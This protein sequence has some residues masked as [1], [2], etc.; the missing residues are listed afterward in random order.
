MTKNGRIIEKVPEHLPEHALRL[1][2]AVKDLPNVEIF[3]NRLE[4][5]L[6]KFLPG[7]DL[8]VNFSPDLLQKIPNEVVRKINEE[9]T[10]N[11]R[12]TLYPLGIAAGLYGL[13]E[14]KNPQ[15]FKEE[16]AKIMFTPKVRKWF[17]YT[18]FAQ[19]TLVGYQ[20]EYRINKIGF[21]GAG[22]IMNAIYSYIKGK[23][24]AENLFDHKDP[25]FRKKEGTLLDFFIAQALETVFLELEEAEKVRTRK[26]EVKKI[27]V[28]ELIRKLNTVKYGEFVTYYEAAGAR[29]TLTLEVLDELKKEIPEDKI[30]KHFRACVMDLD[31][32]SIKHLQENIQN[33]DLL[34]STMMAITGNV[35]R[36]QNKKH[37]DK[38][39]TNTNFNTTVFF[40]D[41]KFKVDVYVKTGLDDYVGLVAQTDSDQQSQE[42]QTLAK[43]GEILRNHTKALLREPLRTYLEVLVRD[44]LTV[45]KKKKDTDNKDSASFENSIIGKILGLSENQMIKSMIPE[46]AYVSHTHNIKNYLKKDGVL[47]TAIFA[48]ERLVHEASTA[49]DMK[50]EQIQDAEKTQQLEELFSY[51]IKL[52]GANW[53]TLSR[54]KE[55]FI[56]KH[57]KFFSNVEVQSHRQNDANFPGLHILIAR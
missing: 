55:W 20:G 22:G 34:T 36:T 33:D 27:V 2:K 54:S 7:V 37:F 10:G 38:K 1:A 50:E 23:V 32:D 13:Q 29:G 49:K 19:R 56:K 21:P 31:E 8:N 46:F 26:D 9:I 57:T 14:T 5:R 17:A 42:R 30:K 11:V 28:K 35:L 47:V 16:W 3:K 4:H 45:L 40:K 52:L 53:S 12:E 51:G 48:E 24:P 41:G 25:M 15:K 43:R 44:T 39:N 18:L 6:K